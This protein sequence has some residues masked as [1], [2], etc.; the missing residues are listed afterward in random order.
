MQNTGELE[1][2]VQ[3]ILNEQI[4]KKHLHINPYIMQPA[5]EYLEEQYGCGIC[6]E[7]RKL[8]ILR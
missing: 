7:D 8:T 4:P 1:Q 3:H 5:K 6:L 2:T